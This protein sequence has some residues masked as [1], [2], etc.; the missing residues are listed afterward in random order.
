MT[1]KLEFIDILKDFSADGSGLFSVS[2]LLRKY[3]GITED[4][5]KLN[6]KFVKADEKLFGDDDDEDMDDDNDNDK[7]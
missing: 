1:K 6:R 3:L 7:W 5:L 2:Y 4:E